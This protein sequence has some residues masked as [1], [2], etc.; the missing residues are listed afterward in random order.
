MN[1]LIKCMTTQTSIEIMATNIGFWK[2]IVFPEKKKESNE[3]FENIFNFLTS[4][5]RKGDIRYAVE[6]EDEDEEKLFAP[7]VHS[8]KIH[9]KN[10]IKGG[11]AVGFVFTIYSM[12]GV[13]LRF[14]SSKQLLDKLVSWE[15]KNRKATH[16]GFSIISPKCRSTFSVYGFQ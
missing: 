8:F 7:P 1:S 6:E 14:S 5:L 9:E 4:F 15:S 3:M 13:P 2:K 16:A 10:G 11:Q 12:M